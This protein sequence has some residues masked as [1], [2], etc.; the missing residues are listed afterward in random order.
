MGE[1]TTNYF[2]CTLG[3]AAGIQSNTPFSTV[4]HLIEQQ[5]NSNPHLPAFA[6]PVPG[7]TT[8]TW[9]YQIY[10]FK[11]VHNGSLSSANTFQLQLRH[12]SSPTVALLCPSS[13]DFIFAWLGLMRAGFSVLIIAPQCQPAAIVHLCSSCNVG[14]LFYDEAYSELAQSASSI[15]TFDLKCQLLAKQKQPLEV[16]VPSATSKT[17]SSDDIAF[18]FHTSG[19]STGLPKPI[20]QSHHAAV[21][22]L[23]ALDGRK[24][25]TFTTTPLYHG[26][27]ADCLRAWTSSALI[28]LFPGADLPI[29]SKNILL[30]MECAER[31]AQEEKNPPVSY[32]A[33]VP[34][35]LQML[36]DEND[37]MALLQAMELISVGGAALP[38]N[39]GDKLVDNGVNLVSR[40]GSAECGFLLSSHRLYKSDKEWQYLRLPA[41]SKH[42]SFEPEVDDGNLSQLIVLSTWPHV[43]KSN[44][45]DG[46]FATS[47]LFEPHPSIP[48]AW[49]YHSRNDSQ[50]TL[51]TGKKFDPSPVEDSISSASPLIRDVL[52]FG[53]HQQVPGLLVFP[54][55]T[56][57]E[58]KGAD[59]E[60]EIWRIVQD[61]NFQGQDHTRISRNMITILTQDEDPLPKSSKGTILRNVANGKYAKQIEAVYNG[62]AQD[63]RTLLSETSSEEDVLTAVRG[64]ILAITNGKGIL[65]N[66]ADFYQHGIDSAMCSQI[67]G[68]LAKIIGRDVKLPWSVVYDCGNIAAL[69]KYI[70]D[71]LQGK[72]PTESKDIHQAMFDLATKFSNFPSGLQLQPRRNERSTTVLLT[73]ATGSLGAHILSI[74]LQDAS[75][76]RIVCLVRAQTDE[77]ARGRVEAALTR[78]RKTIPEV[79][80]GR[81]SCY[82][83]TLSSTNLGLS[84]SKYEALAEEVTHII[85]SAWAVNFSLPLQ[86]FSDNL[87]GLHKL[88][89]LTI[90]SKQ[91]ASLIFCSSTASV[92]SSPT[93]PIHESISSDPKDADSLGYSQS[94]WVAERICATASEVE[95]MQ[96]RVSIL[97]I[98]QLTGDTENGI[99]NLSEAWPLMLSTVNK[100]GCLPQLDGEKL[101]WLPVDIAA[102]AVCDITLSSKGNQIDQNGNDG[103]EE[104]CLVYHLVANITDKTPTWTNLLHW[105]QPA[106]TEPFDIV[107]PQIWLHKLRRLDGHPAQALLGL[108]DRAYGGRRDGKEIQV[109]PT[110][111]FD[112]AKAGAVSAAMR[113]LG[114]VDRELVGRIWM[115]LEGEMGG[116]S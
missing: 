101:A 73:G 56:S 45:P 41:N 23:P 78:R 60:S 20:P 39:I 37:G 13:V 92:L 33:S 18:L 9:E 54:S 107:A 115:W 30:S 28:W 44:R 8:A 58:R 79:S 42:L 21:G 19:T 94:K 80:Q 89:D 50:I 63:S 86:S 113:E 16:Q 97:R 15:A 14:F 77:Q 22:V 29:T 40:F 112:T 55:K 35:I 110:W 24:S 69:S 38:Q 12:Y 76:S 5:A 52:I 1:L 109:E 104:K 17:H 61:V 49:K 48:S 106:R 85:H 11:D 100:L 62:G 114:V 88:L 70:S 91:K 3:E 68:R 71:T 32:F 65:D 66:H 84:H 93:H 75:I 102:K 83:S 53:N 47:D 34:Y 27:I 46:S 6:F 111:S 7:R 98:G 95:G 64:I 36:A 99:W 82:A 10:S 116:E 90:S 51:S 74:L 103:T 26:G 67:R 43:A 4:S 105:I 108:W 25:A 2:V 81:L 31:A 59:V 57:A 87:A 72:S 96:G